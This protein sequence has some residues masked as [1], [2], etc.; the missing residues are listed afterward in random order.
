MFTPLPKSILGQLQKVMVHEDGESWTHINSMKTMEVDEVGYA[1]LEQGLKPNQLVRYYLRDSDDFVW[2]VIDQTT[3]LWIWDNYKQA[4]QPE[5]C[6]LDEGPF[7]EYTDSIVES[8][9]EI[10]H[11]YKEQIIAVSVGYDK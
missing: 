11:L 8:R 3:A 5:L 1:L 2:H 4:G 6:I 7:D 9:T 10:E